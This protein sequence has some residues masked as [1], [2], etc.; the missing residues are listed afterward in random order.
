M[1]GHI[2]ARRLKSPADQDVLLGG[3][4][5]EPVIGE[6]GLLGPR[7]TTLGIEQQPVAVEDDRTHVPR[8]CHAPDANG[9]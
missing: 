7:P 8:K 4:K 3:T 9:D 2:G 6:Q 5:S 1:Y